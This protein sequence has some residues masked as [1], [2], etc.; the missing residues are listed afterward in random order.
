MVLF[1]SS[2]SRVGLIGRDNDHEKEREPPLN[3]GENKDK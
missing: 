3:K 1:R 2:S